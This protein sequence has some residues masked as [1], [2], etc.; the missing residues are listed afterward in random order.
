[1]NSVYLRQFQIVKPL[2]GY[3]QDELLNWTIQCH[4][5]AE[6][7][8]SPIEL[9]KGVN[10]DVIEKLFK[11]Y[12][13]KSSQISQRYI[14]CNDL[15]AGDSNSAKSKDIYRF[16][17]KNPHGVDI[18]IRTQFFA[19]R[20]YEV[21][22]NLY[23]LE[24]AENK[25]PDHLIHVTCT[26]YISPSAAQRIVTEP[27][28]NHSTDV[29]HAYHMG[30]YAAMPAV[31][32]AKSLVLSECTQ[33]KDFVTDVV[34]TEMC[35]LHMNPLAQTPEQ[36]VV[37]TLFGDGHIKYSVAAEKIAESGKN[38]KVV[39]MLERILPHSQGDMSWVPA[40]WGLQMNLSR[41]VPTKIRKELK[42]F[43]NDL[44][45]KANVSLE[46][47]LAAKFA[48]HPGGPKIIDSVKEA[49]ELSADQIAESRKVLF[50]RG[51]MSSATLPHV[52]SEILENN[53]PSGSY[54]ISFA[55]GPGLTLFGSVFEVC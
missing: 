8:R 28:W 6:S 10:L 35:G 48:I 39:A 25:K 17:S 46:V 42:T 23:D 38:L 41:D 47:A 2:Y 19:R 55:F 1:M 27:K 15:A 34:H 54:I 52:W 53:L 9:S 22:K 26:G 49:L 14:E 29:T 16:D 32:V 21:F 44:F 11:R 43:A 36:M 12:A 3:S 4:Q 37:Q 51:N 13:V 45:Q 5:S 33:K 30:C 20:A 18:N 7:Y 31:R 50:E 24:N 40:P